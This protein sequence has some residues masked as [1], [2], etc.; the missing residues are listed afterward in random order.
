MYQG[1]HFVVQAEVVQRASLMV[2]RQGRSLRKTRRLLPTILTGEPPKSKKTHGKV[3]DWKDAMKMQAKITSKGQ[4][5]VPVK[6]RRRWG[7][8]PA[9]SFSSGRTATISAFGR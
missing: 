3:R 1:T 4:I 2:V 5:T 9:I 7:C 8:E 6:V